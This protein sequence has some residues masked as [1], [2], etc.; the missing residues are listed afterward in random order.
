MKNEVRNTRKSRLVNEMAEAIWELV[1]NGNSAPSKGE[2]VTAVVDA[3]LGDAASPAIRALMEDEVANTLERY[4][5]DACKLAAEFIGGKSP[6]VYHLVSKRFYSAKR[7]IPRDMEEAQ[8]FVVCFGNGRRGPAAG[9]RF[10]C[11][12][13]EPDAMLLVATKKGI[14]VVNAAI[15][16]HQERLFRMATSPAIPTDARERLCGNK[17]LENGNNEEHHA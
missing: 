13:D 6:A 8:G 17:L 2:I 12:E 10:P 1:A 4:F 16:T 14:D 5:Y 3:S 9:V 11:E 7:R 15:N